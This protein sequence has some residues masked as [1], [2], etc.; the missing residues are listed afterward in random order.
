MPHL[1]RQPANNRILI[2]S[3]YFQPHLGGVEKHVQK[4]SLILAQKGYDLTILTKLYQPDLP[5][6]EEISCHSETNEQFLHPIK[7]KRFEIKP[8]RIIGL[9]LI[10][11]NL[12]KNYRTLVKKADKVIIHDV[13]IWYFPFVFLFPN[14]TVITVMHGWEGQFPIPRKNRWLKQLAARFSTRV[15]AIGRYIE[16][17]YRIKADL[18]AHGGV[19]PTNPHQLWAD[20]MTNYRLRFYYL[21]RLAADTG[22]PMLLDSLGQIKQN[23]PEVFAKLE[24]EFIGDGHSQW[25]QKCNSI[26]KVI[27]WVKEAE[28]KD[29][30]RSAHFCFA[31]G[32]LSAL[33]AMAQ[34]CVVLAA[35]KNP[36]K[37]DYWL[38]SDLNGP[39]KVAIAPDELVS[40]IREYSQEEADRFTQGKR[41]QVLAN[42]F[43][44]EQ[45]ANQYAHW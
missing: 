45:I 25:R 40:W 1:D 14:K 27:G 24:I 20:K 31:G 13:F 21:G 35:G 38:L 32:Y 22:L 26:G 16:K 2:L 4:T 36:L 44:W 10:W 17:Y 5:V 43:G 11:W 41:A 8:F 34:G 12:I 39:V 18:V 19:E 23:Y 15:L 3:H 9:L 42:K 6:E 28:V 33:E 29:R 7:I 30:L 37:Q